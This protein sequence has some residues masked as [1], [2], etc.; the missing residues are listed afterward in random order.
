M[1][2]PTIF[3]LLHQ[4]VIDAVLRIQIS[5]DI[6]LADIVK[7]IKIK[8]FH[9]TFFQLLLEDFFYLRHVC[10]IISGKLGCQIKA[11]SIIIL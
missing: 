5:I 11:V 1:L 6:H 10:Q 9:L 4:I 3:L 7:Q 8:V 2:D